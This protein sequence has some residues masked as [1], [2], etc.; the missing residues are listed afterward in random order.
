MSMA[1][2]IDI[3]KFV[4]IHQH[5]AQIDERGGSRRIDSLRQIGWQRR[6]G[7]VARPDARP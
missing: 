2:S 1:L 4:G 7:L 5:V 3:Q 6:L